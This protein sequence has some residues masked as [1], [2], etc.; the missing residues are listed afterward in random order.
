RTAAI[1]IPAGNPEARRIEHRVAGGDVN[2]YLMLA[3]ILGAA[4]TG[5]EDEVE[6]APPV[7]GNAYAMDLPQ[8]PTTWEAAIDAFENSDILYRF[9]P[10]EL[11]RNLVQ[12][13]RQELHYLAELSPEERVELYLDT[14]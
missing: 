6:P 9:L 14:V 13:K 2:P 11:I 12:T 1:R 3:A 10:K 4:L 8:I 7:N 5:I